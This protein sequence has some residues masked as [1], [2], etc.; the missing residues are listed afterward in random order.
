MDLNRLVAGRI[1]GHRHGDG[2]RRCQHSGR[3]LARQRRDGRRGRQRRLQRRKLDGRRLLRRRNLVVRC[4]R[5]DAS[6]T[7]G[8]QSLVRSAGLGRRGQQVSQR[9]GQGR[10]LGRGGRCGRFRLGRTVD[11]NGGRRMAI[12]RF[13]QLRLAAVAPLLGMFQFFP[14]NRNQQMN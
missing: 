3:L 1:D 13:R 7:S 10:F 9:G 4:G 11:R 6:A 12:H 2:R 8:I 5:F 14:P